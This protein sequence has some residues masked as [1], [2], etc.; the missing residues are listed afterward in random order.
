MLA[1]RVQVKISSGAIRM[2]TSCIRRT[3]SGRSFS[4]RSAVCVSQ[5]QN[6]VSGADGAGSFILALSVRSG[7]NVLLLIFRTFRKKRL[8]LLM[9]LRALFGAEPFRFGAMIGR[10]SGLASRGRLISRH[11]YFPQHART[12]PLPPHASLVLLPQ[13]VEV[14]HMEHTRVRSADT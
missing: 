1:F 9:L 13:T 4:P 2:R 6:N 11:I 14:W 7:V 8:R 10:L 5:S 12:A 3:T